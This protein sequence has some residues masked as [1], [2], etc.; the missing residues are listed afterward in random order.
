MGVKWYHNSLF[1]SFHL[2]QLRYGLWL[3]HSTVY[4]AMQT[5]CFVF[6]KPFFMNL[7]QTLILSQGTGS[8]VL[9]DL[10]HQLSEG[11]AHN[12]VLTYLK[13]TTTIS[14]HLWQAWL[15]QPII[16][17]P[18]ATKFFE[19]LVM[20]HIKSSTNISLEPHPYTWCRNCQLWGRG[21]H[22][23]AA[24]WTYFPQLHHLYDWV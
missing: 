10:I 12:C 20:V 3:G 17:K 19:R 22:W 1:K 11:L 7:L 24:F 8:W 2:W 4:A 14:V 21:P 5:T 15:T 9:Q 18:T 13:T 16:L 23:G 6:L